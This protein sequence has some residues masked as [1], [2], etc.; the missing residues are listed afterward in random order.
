MELTARYRVPAVVRAFVP[1]HHGTRLIT[2]FYRK[3]SAA[4]PTVD[5]EKFRYPGP[6]P[7]SRETA[8]V[9]LAD[10]VEAVV[11]SSKDRSFEKIDELVD[12]VIRERVTEASSTTATSPSATSGNRR[13]VQ[14]H[15]PRH[16]SPASSIPPRQRPNS[17][18]RASLISSPSSPMEP[19][20]LERGS[21][22]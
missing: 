18:L 8:I 5:P 12:S 6:R 21:G 13:V 7:Q 2:Y 15:S 17:R 22:N 1:E 14:G 20:P 19:P 16:L 9:M 3:A 11:R 10:S 4:D